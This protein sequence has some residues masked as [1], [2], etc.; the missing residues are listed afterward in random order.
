[1]SKTMKEGMV[2]VKKKQTLAQAIT[3]LAGNKMDKY[4]HS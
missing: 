2:K 3:T 4:L 1:M